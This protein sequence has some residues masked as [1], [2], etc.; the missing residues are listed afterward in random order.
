MVMTEEEK[1]Q[2]VTEFCPNADNITFGHMML[3]LDAIPSP[4]LTELRQRNMSLLIIFDSL[5]ELNAFAKDKNI[6]P[7]RVKCFKVP[8]TD[9]PIKTDQHEVRIGVGAE[10]IMCDGSTNY[11]CANSFCFPIVTNNTISICPGVFLAKK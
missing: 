2:I 11:F 3:L 5:Q 6:L 9:L 10:H 4:N 8:E 7:K 1:K